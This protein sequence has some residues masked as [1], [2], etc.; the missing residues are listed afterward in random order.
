MWAALVKRLEGSESPLT[1]EKAAQD[2]TNRSRKEDSANLKDAKAE[3]LDGS[4][5][6]LEKG[7]ARRR[8]PAGPSSLAVEWQGVPRGSPQEK[9]PGFQEAEIEDGQNARGCELGFLSLSESY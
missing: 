8:D 2:K 5:E 7:V 4:W 3:D 9:V 1:S 6:G